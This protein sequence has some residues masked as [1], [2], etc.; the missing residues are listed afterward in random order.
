FLPRGVSRLIPFLTFIVVVGITVLFSVLSGASDGSSK[1]SQYA[2]LVSV[3]VGWIGRSFHEHLDN[4]TLK[5]YKH[6][7][8]WNCPF[9]HPTPIAIHVVRQFISPVLIF[10]QRER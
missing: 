6:F 10:V 9:F 2:N 3:F 7:A 8:G 4:Y 1:S 5:A